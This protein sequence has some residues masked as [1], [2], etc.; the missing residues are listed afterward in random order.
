MSR[1]KVLDVVVLVAFVGLGWFATHPSKPSTIPTVSA[2]HKVKI[3]PTLGFTPNVNPF[4]ANGGWYYSYNVSA[5]GI[6]PNTGVVTPYGT[7]MTKMCMQKSESDTT[8]V[9]CWEVKVVRK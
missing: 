5:A 1:I 7:G 8:L 4:S 2:S 6:N 9:G 3:D